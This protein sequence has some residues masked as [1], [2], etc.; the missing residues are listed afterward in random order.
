M[1]PV[2][3]IFLGVAHGSTSPSLSRASW[4]ESVICWRFS[5]ARQ[6]DREVITLP[7]GEHTEQLSVRLLF[8]ERQEFS[9]EVE[10]VVLVVVTVVVSMQ[11]SVRQ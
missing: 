11:P 1:S 6:I 5:T 2:N 3:A 8:L 4:E 7:L 10:L 9:I